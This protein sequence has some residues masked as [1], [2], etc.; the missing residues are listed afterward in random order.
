MSKPV[1][2]LSRPVVK[3]LYNTQHTGDVIIRLAKALGGTLADAFAWDSYDA[4]LKET[5]GY[6]WRVMVEKGFWSYP[7]FV[8]QA[9]EEAFD[10]V[11][12]KFEFVR[13]ETESLKPFEPVKIEGDKN[14]YPLILMPYDS[15]R[16]ANSVIGDPPF[17]MKSVDDTVLKGTE[18]F[19]EINPKTAGEQG[20]REG[21]LAMLSTPVGKAK[22][23][24]HLFDG[25]MP[26]IVALPRGLGHTAYDEY[27][28]GKGINFNELIGP[29]EDPV[30]GLD[31]AWGIRVKLAK[32]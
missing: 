3:P 20:L 7:G 4:C 13:K 22:V 1:I 2:G 31:T 25:I 30:S 10:T 6:K 32:A 14:S 23:K 12:G 9:R 8:A 15:I 26:G 11:S 27:L 28:A 29:V 24:V 17:V 21:Q 16:L 18:V 19:I 5:L